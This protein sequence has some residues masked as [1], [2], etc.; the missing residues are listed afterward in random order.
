MQSAMN[1]ME[2][3]ARRYNRVLKLAHTA[4]DL[5]GSEKFQSARAERNSPYRD[6]YVWSD[7]DQKYKD[8]RIIFLDT[9][10]PTGPGIRLPVNI[11]GTASTPP[12]PT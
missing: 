7:T 10:N 6:Y 8:A 11:S 3:S 5:A 1:Q 4:A 12:S 2:P 9:E